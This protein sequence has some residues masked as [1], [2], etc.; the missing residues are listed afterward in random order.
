MNTSEMFLRR[1]DDSIDKVFQ[2]FLSVSSGREEARR[3]VQSYYMEAWD[4]LVAE[5]E[6][7]A[8][9]AS[10]KGYLRKSFQG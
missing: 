4:E 8:K 1:F 10:R 5:Q 6:L 9:N 3:M 7:A 2:Q